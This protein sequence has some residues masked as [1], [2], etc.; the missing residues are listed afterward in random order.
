MHR[1]GSLL[2]V[3]VA[4]IATSCAAHSKAAETP[5]GLEER[6]RKLE[7]DNAKYAGALAFLQQIY[8]QQ[9]AQRESQEDNE[10][11]P[12]AIF[13]V[14]VAAAVAAG[15]VAGPASAAV[16]IVEAFDFA[17]PF[18]AELNG[19][20]DDVVRDYNGKVRVVYLNMLIHQFALP[21]HLG[22][23]A[24]AKQGQFLAFKK[25]IWEKTFPAYASERDPSMFDE[26][27]MLEVGKAA[28][29]DAAKMQRD[30]GSEECK[31]R[32]AADLGELQRFEVNGTPTLFING[33]M[34]LELSKEGL[35][36][37]IDEK[38]KV[39]EASGVAAADYYAKEVLGKGEKKFRSRRDA[40]SQ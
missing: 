12:G 6:V 19:L 15:Q 7:A 34:A 30:L 8:E 18:C 20:L 3:A 36:K 29:L 5:A 22:S 10:P 11:A 1:F 21:A 17:C 26:A 16:T 27:H 35:R 23:C 40:A 28:G 14:P 31:A 32:I 2:L 25:V 37:L 33:T 24:A 4:S 13:A 39:V 38:L 9:V